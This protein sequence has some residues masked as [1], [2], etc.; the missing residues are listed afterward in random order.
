V[1]GRGL[2][3]GRILVLLVVVLL[4]LLVVVLLLLLVVVVLL[5]LVVVLL[6]LVVVVLLLVLLLVVVVILVLLVVVLVL[7][8]VVVVGVVVVVVVVAVAVAAF[9]DADVLES[10]KAYGGQ[11]QTVFSRLTKKKQGGLAETL[12]PCISQT[13]GRRAWA[14]FLLASLELQMTGVFFSHFQQLLSFLALQWGVCL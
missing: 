14:Q 8:V 11:C 9:W 2:G 1:P 5:L 4:L 12:R 13:N 7:L 3:L 6:L 10:C